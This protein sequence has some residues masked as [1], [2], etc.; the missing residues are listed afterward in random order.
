MR[1]DRKAKK[2]FVEDYA[3]DY[4]ERKASGRVQNG[5]WSWFRPGKH[6]DDDDEEKEYA[7]GE[8][9]PSEVMIEGRIKDIFNCFRLK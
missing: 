4:E 5:F 6:Y 2:A 3:D 1:K 7:H 8:C 9:T